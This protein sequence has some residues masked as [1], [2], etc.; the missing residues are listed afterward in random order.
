MQ[1]KMSLKRRALS[2]GNNTIVYNMRVII[3]DYVET[4]K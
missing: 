3:K 4:T 2:T 1:T